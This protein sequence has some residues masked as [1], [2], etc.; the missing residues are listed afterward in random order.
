MSLRPRKPAAPLMVDFR[1]GIAI[2]QTISD[3]LANIESKL[4]EDANARLTSIESKLTELQ[5]QH[6]LA[7]A[8]PGI[9]HVKK[10]VF[11]KLARLE[12]GKPTKIAPTADQWIRERQ[13]LSTLQASL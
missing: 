3:R 4:N 2:D 8:D 13:R 11:D 10:A 5:A 12:A 7:K 1:E 6:L 9:E